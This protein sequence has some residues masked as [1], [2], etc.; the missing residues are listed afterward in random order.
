MYE[1]ASTSAKKMIV[2]QLIREVR[3]SRGYRLSIDFNI[4]LEEFGLQSLREFPIS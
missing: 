2:S 1:T 3:V 4:S